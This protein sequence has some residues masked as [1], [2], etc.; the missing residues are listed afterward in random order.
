MRPTSW[1]SVWYVS[2]SPSGADSPRCRASFQPR[3]KASWRPRLRA[4]PPIGIWRWAASPANRIR[5]L[6]YRVSWR[7]ASPNEFAQSGVPPLMS[8]PVTRFQ[9][10][11]ISPNS[12]SP[13]RGSACEPNSCTITRVTPSRVA[14]MASPA[15]SRS[16]RRLGM[17]T[18]ATSARS[19]SRPASLPGN[20]APVRRRTVESSPSHPT[21]KPPR[22]TTVPSGPAAV[23]STTSPRSDTSR[24]SWPRRMSTPSESAHSW[25]RASVRV[26]GIFHCPG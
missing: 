9:T 6:R 12:G 10:A 14:A 17:V 21:R 4:W 20:S 16:K 2:S 19:S 22:T 11:A 18:P 7:L 13:V 5:P 25:S 26:W 3:L 23:A 1:R 15:G 24:S 8:S